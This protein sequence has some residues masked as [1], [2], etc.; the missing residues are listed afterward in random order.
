M[1]YQLGK[2]FKRSVRVVKK[3]IVKR[4][5]LLFLGFTSTLWFLIRVIPK[6]S[7]ATYPCMQASAP[8]MS[9]FVV[10]LI[11]FW[12]TSLVYKKAKQKW[13]ASKY[14]VSGLLFVIAT[15]GA[16]ILLPKLNAD[17]QEKKVELKIWY[18]PN[19][20]LGTA[21]GVFP[22]RVAWGHNPNVATWDMKTG[23][24]WEANYNNQIESDKLMSQTLLGLTGTKNEKK[25][26]DNL[27]QYFN[28]GQNKGKVGYQKGE[29]IA[30]KINMNNT[31]SHENSSEINANPTLILSLLKSLIVYAGIPQENITVAD[32]SRFITNNIFDKCHVVYPN[33]HF[34]DHDGGDGREKSSYIP[35]VIPY[36][37][38]NGKVATG[39]AS[40]IVDADYI[41]NLALLKGHVGQGVTLCAKNYF[42]CTS[43][44]SDW[45]KNTHSF[46]FS[47]SKKGEF[48]Y[49]IYPDFL[50]HKHLGAKTMLFLIDAIYGNKLLDGVPANKWKLSPFNGNW[51]NSLF[52]SQD[53]V[54]IDAVALDFAL[55]EWP[56]G[57]DMMYSDYSLN[58]CAMADNPPS[59][60]KY[61]PERDGS[62]LK[63]LGTSEHW[64]NAIE[65]KYSRNLSPKTGKGIELKY[66]STQ[67]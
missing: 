27:F 45:R 62:V 19:S 15:C 5:S 49:S 26:W 7:R 23:F 60:I 14:V 66:C 21:H 22:G 28:N 4:V 41:I 25:A 33:V 1:K 55:A 6:P 34:V 63:S 9:A 59:G 54:A 8:F 53:G 10:W 24:W 39:L 30:I 67:K 56:D 37:I 13:S 35:N 40:C 64:N 20:P 32:P 52:A 48:R 58:E 2:I 51:P 16:F 29:K 50:G 17:A 57:K 3:P 36:S 38:D 46:G 12:G 18:K 31:S 61:D 42:G 65:K 43:I 11:G 47:Q 44:E